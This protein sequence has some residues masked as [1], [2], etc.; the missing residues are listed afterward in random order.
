MLRANQ[1]DGAPDKRTRDNMALE[2]SYEGYVSSTQDA[3]I[4]F[5]ACLQG[6]LCHT[7]RRPHDRERPHLVRSGCVFIY[8]ENSS[9]I[10]RWT[11]GVTWSPSRILGNFLVYRELDKPFPPG[12]KKRAMRKG[13]RS[14]AT[15]SSGRPGE[16]Y[17][18]RSETPSGDSLSSARHYR[19]REP[20]EAAQAERAHQPEI[21]RALVGSLVDSYG[22]K[23]DGL[24]KKTMSVHIGGVTHHLV[25]YYSVEDVLSGRLRSPTFDDTFR[26]IRIRPELL[27]QSFRSPISEG[28]TLDGQIIAYPLDWND[29][30]A[31]QDYMRAVQQSQINS[32]I[33]GAQQHGSPSSHPQHPQFRANNLS[34]DALPS[35]PPHYFAPPATTPAPVTGAAVAATHPVAIKDE[36]A[37]YRATVPSPYNPYDTIGPNGLPTPQAS[38]PSSSDSTFPG[39]YHAAD[40]ASYGSSQHGLPP[41]TTTMP[42]ALTSSPAHP[43]ISAPNGLSHPANSLPTIPTTTQSYH[44]YSVGPPPVSNGF[45]SNQQAATEA[46]AAFSSHSASGSAS[47]FRRPHVSSYPTPP[48]SAPM[49]PPF[50]DPYYAQGPP[51]HPTQSPT[52]A[53]DGNGDNSVDDF[54]LFPRQAQGQQQ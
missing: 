5:E 23:E 14:T 50:Y 42:A 45:T 53:P 39:A 44:A 33:A 11:D 26:N 16:P 19:E 6:D 3:L 2:P 18:A 28:P 51:Q 9:G 30:Q 8:E 21:E 10:K 12:E 37:P 4:L 20:L 54:T 40:R 15:N 25:S 29:H 13:R 22:F 34:N 27:N 32:A 52:L 49:G 24:V 43:G 35:I 41:H 1:Q 47:S 17:H 31:V 46:A 38:N 36:F 7:G 48:T